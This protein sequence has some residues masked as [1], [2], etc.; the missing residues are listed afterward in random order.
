MEIYFYFDIFIAEESIKRYDKIASQSGLEFFDP[1]GFLSVWKKS[2]ISNEYL[3]EITTR[4]K[5]TQSTYVTNA[6]AATHF[7]Y[8]RYIKIS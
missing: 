5:E 7:P 1:V 6:Y 3:E 8:L 2:D 4:A